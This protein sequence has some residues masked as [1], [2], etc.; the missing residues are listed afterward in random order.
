MRKISK[1]S[2]RAFIN[3]ETFNRD[4]TSVEIS[5]NNKYVYM[6]LF[7]NWIARKNLENGNI[8][9]NNCGYSTVTTKDRLNAII[10]YSDYNHNFKHIFQK[11]HT[12]YIYKNVTDKKGCIVD[13][14][15]TPFKSNDWF[16]LVGDDGILDGNENNPY[17]EYNPLKGALMVSKFMELMQGDDIAQSNKQ[18]KRIFDTVPGLSFPDDWDTLP[19]VEKNKRLNKIKDIGGEL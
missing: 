14:Y 11:N 8:N 7:G 16:S 2:A 19:E 15:A 17:D 4:N 1:D 5:P 6:Y 12:W 10:Y 9:I 3:G 13:G 18:Q